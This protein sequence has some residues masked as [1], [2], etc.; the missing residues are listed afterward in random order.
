M[1]DESYESE[2]PADNGGWWPPGNLDRS[3][4]LTTPKKPAWSEV[5]FIF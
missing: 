2:S 4:K 1:S 5:H 3:T